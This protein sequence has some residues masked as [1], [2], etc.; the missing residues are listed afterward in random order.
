MMPI[1][2]ALIARWMTERLLPKVC[3]M[4]MISIAENV[5]KPLVVGL[6]NGLVIIVINTFGMEI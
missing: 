6:T 3:A 2:R 1:A 5:H 4:I